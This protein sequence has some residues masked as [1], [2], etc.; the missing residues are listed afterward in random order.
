MKNN[1]KTSTLEEK[2]TGK[3]VVYTTKTFSVN[4]PQNW[5][6]E[7]NDFVFCIY[8]P[9]GRGAVQISTYKRI[10]G[11]K[12]SL[13]EKIK[14][15]ARIDNVQIIEKRDSVE[16]N[17]LRDLS[18]WKMKIVINKN[19][20]AFITYNCRS[21]RVDQPELEKVNNIFDSFQFVKDD[22]SK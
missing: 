9:N 16:T 7:L 14:K 19:A 20:T 8:D 21:D 12:I 11:E 6:E 1:F 22:K 4:V 18:F 5:I 2:K 3:F 13:T 15:M 10:G 17:F